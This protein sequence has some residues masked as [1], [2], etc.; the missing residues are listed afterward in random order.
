MEES[1]IVYTIRWRDL[2]ASEDTLKP[3][4]KLSNNSDLVNNHDL[5]IH[6]Y[7]FRLGTSILGRRG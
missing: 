6:E 1:S 7:T 2:D 4:A 3:M 5:R